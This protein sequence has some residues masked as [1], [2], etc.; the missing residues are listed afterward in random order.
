MQILE[1]CLSKIIHIIDIIGQKG[2]KM[3]QKKRNN[4]PDNRQNFLS[5][6]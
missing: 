6:G 1:G 3:I 5:G 2:P 4:I